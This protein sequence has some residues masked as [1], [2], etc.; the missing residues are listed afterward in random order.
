MLY[1]FLEYNNGVLFIRLEGNLTRDTS[2]KINNYLIPVIIKQKV[3]QLVINISKVEKID[4]TGYEA[5]I[6][7]RDASREIRGN[8]YFSNNNNEHNKML[9]KLHVNVI[10]SD[11]LIFN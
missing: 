5:L 1:M 2:Y 7:L 3:K 6:N 9:K 10:N 8:I 11:N 4:L